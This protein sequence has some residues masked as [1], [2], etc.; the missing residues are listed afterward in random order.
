VVPVKELYVLSP[1]MCCSPYMLILSMSCAVQAMVY[2]LVDFMQAVSYAD[3]ILLLSTS[4]SYHGL[5]ALLNVYAK[6][7]N[8]G[9]YSSIT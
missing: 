8:T 9:T 4:S 2:T 3:G 6:F 1:R 7:G 5:Q